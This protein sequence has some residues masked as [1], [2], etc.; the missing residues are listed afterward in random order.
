[1]F[2]KLFEG[3]MLKRSQQT[4][5]KIILPI[6]AEFFGYS[7]FLFQDI[8]KTLLT[9]RGPLKPSTVNFGVQKQCSC[10]GSSVNWDDHRI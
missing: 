10:Q 6:Y 8:Q 4:N 1:M 2:K 3:K 5:L 9:G 7:N